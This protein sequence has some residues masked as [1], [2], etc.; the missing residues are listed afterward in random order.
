MQDI[1]EKHVIITGAASGIGKAIAVLLGNKGANLMLLDKDYNSLKAVKSYIS[2]K[3]PNCH[4]CF[5]EK[6]D[7]RDEKR[8]KECIA[9]FIKN[10]GKIDVLINNAGILDYGKLHEQDPKRWFDVINTNLYGTFLCSRYVLPHMVK[11]KK[12]HIIN[13]SSVYGKNASADSSAY[14]ASKFGIRG[15]SQSLQQEVG[16]YNIR[17]SIIHP[18]TTQT[19][20]FKGTPFK[21]NKNTALVPEDI[22][23][24]IYSTIMMRPGSTISDVDVVPIR[25]PYKGSKK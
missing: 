24:T 10:C 15:L 20:L 14:C 21:P 2:E 3:C 18:S 13:M 9:K 5:A 1:S 22:A 12:G 16:R 11:R 6:C 4:T 25:D 19:N 8:I 17:V 7:I 23:R